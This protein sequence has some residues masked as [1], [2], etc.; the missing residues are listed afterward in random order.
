MHAT[1]LRLISGLALLFLPLACVDLDD[2]VVHG[3]VNVLVVD[4]TITNIA[5]PQIIRLNRSQSDRLTGRFGTVPLTKASVEVIVD[6]T[7]IIACHETIPGSYQLPADFKGQIGHTYQLRFSLSDG[8]AYESTS[9]L[10][11]E[12]TPISQVSAKFNPTSLPAQLADKSI[13]SYRGAHELAIDWQDPATEHN[14]YRWDYTLWEKQRWCK[15]CVQGEYTQYKIIG[16][17]GNESC[18]LTNDQL[19]EDC[20]SPPEITMPQYN[21]GGQ[22]L[23]FVYDYTC[24]SQCW[25]IIY[26]YAINVFDDKYSNGGFIRAR[27]IGQIPYYQQEGCLVEIRQL[28]MSADSYRYF[29]L[30]QQQTQNT[31]G[32]ADTP[33]SIPV[34]NITNVT[35][36]SEHVVGYFSA[37][38][39]ATKRI[40]LD[41]KDAQ[42]PFPGLFQALNGRSPIP[43]ADSAKFCIAAPP[44][45]PPTALCAP[46]KSKTPFKPEGWQD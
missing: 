34:G 30:L 41:R 19:Y 33:P 10:M 9:Q 44:L 27:P 6:S 45:R 12:V 31:G 18:F 8:T 36:H 17:K 1:F 7:Q 11:V 4:G 23:Y 32:V 25:E 21:Y 22:N 5:E 46:S 16:R 20:Y 14:Y 28:S 13:N 42:G 39:V 38:A 15:T 43:E 29:Q 37:S 26:N 35:D 2:I 3:T 40:W 24:R